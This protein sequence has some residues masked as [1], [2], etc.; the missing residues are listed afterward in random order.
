MPTHQE[1]PSAS[2]IRKARERGIRRLYFTA[3]LT[4][5]SLTAFAHVRRCRLRPQFDD[6]FVEYPVE[7]L[8]KLLTEQILDAGIGGLDQR[9]H[10]GGESAAAR[11]QRDEHAALVVRQALALHE[12]DVLHSRQDPGKAGTRQA[13][14]VPD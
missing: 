2:Q 8:R 10:A 14:Y 1:S 9:R 11:R 13:A 3:S 7:I 6:E 4:T 5:P 12:S